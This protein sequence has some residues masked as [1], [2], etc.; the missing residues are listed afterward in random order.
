MVRMKG[1]REV[2]LTMEGCEEE[3]FWPQIGGQTPV[4]AHRLA[5]KHR[6]RYTDVEEEKNFER[7]T[8][9]RKQQQFQMWISHRD[10]GDHRE[11][12][13]SVDF[14]ENMG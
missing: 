14:F 3:E 11:K 2:E 8:G 7:T 9:Y 1:F 12:N 13:I 5:G 10:H 4:A 6:K